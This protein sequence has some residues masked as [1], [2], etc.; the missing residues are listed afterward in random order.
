MLAVLAILVQSW[1]AVLRSS[2]RAEEKD[3]LCEA[4][5][6]TLEVVVGGEL[7]QV[8]GACGGKKSLRLGSR[9]PCRQWNR[10]SGTGGSDDGEA[11]RK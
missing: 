10:L 2:V 1:F 6:R 7:G 5:E 11:Q 9:L 8:S 4:R 3:C